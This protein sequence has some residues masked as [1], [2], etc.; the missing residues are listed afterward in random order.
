ML[1]PA[2]GRPVTLVLPAPLAS[3]AVGPT[4]FTVA[5]CVGLRIGARA[6]ARSQ[7]THGPAGAAAIAAPLRSVA[8][9][10]RR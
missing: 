10:R 9:S 6:T 5:G 1:R 3:S 7:E 8:S 2:H 4:V